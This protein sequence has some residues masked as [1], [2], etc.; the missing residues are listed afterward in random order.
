[1]SFASFW[2]SALKEVVVFS[3]LIPVLLLR[4]LSLPQADEEDAEIEA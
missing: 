3:V 1:E 2:N 4:S